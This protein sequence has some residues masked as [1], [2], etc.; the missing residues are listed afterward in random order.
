MVELVGTG[1]LK[2]RGQ[3]GFKTT[4]SYSVHVYPM[5]YVKGRREIMTEWQLRKFMKTCTDSAIKSTNFA[6]SA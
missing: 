2:A 6:I 1:Q 4:T 3:A 5:D